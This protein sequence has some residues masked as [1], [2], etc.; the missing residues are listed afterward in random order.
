MGWHAG[1]FCARL[2]PVVSHFECMCKHY[3]CRLCNGLYNR[4]LVRLTLGH[5]H[6][7]SCIIMRGPTTACALEAFFPTQ[8]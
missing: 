3:G 7:F 8:T 2:R 1:E 6:S 5:R 4:Q